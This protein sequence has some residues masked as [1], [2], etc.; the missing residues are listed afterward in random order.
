MSSVDGR[1]VR[2]KG[3]HRLRR[4]AQGIFDGVVPD[5][6]TSCPWDSVNE[7]FQMVT[8]ACCNASQPDR[9][10]E[11]GIPNVC[12]GDCAVAVHS[13]TSKCGTFISSSMQKDTAQQFRELEH[14]CVSSMDG[15]ELQV[16]IM[17][18]KC[19]PCESIDCGA[20]GVCIDGSCVC[21]EPTSTVRWQGQT[22]NERWHVGSFEVRS[23]PCTTSEDAKCVGRRYDEHNPWPGA[24]QTDCGGYCGS[25]IVERCEI[26]VVQ[27]GNLGLSQLFDTVS[28]DHHNG[29]NGDANYFARRH[30]S[31]G[32]PGSYCEDYAS[33]GYTEADPPNP[34]QGCHSGQD[35]PPQGLELAV[36]DTITW[37]A[38]GDWYGAT[39][40]GHSSPSN[41][42]SAHSGWRL[43][44]EFGP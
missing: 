39:S 23:G 16:V 17:A 24:P 21:D 14:S 31:V 38:G 37:A 5:D 30:D 10:C 41:Q 20:H 2:S 1:A 44:F 43:C 3:G 29:D 18:A 15:S 4:R 7:R 25:G 13:F 6:K 33:H 34:P 27:E 8:T 32:L 36:G 26:T 35:A 42:A 19:D 28:Y 12:T 22:C 9:S 11:S 40:G